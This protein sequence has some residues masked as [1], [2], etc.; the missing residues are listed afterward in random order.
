[1]DDDVIRHYADEDTF[2]INI[3]SAAASA[4]AAERVGIVLTEIL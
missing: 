4:S 3:S 2:V 1:M